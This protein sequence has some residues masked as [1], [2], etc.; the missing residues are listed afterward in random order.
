MLCSAEEGDDPDLA[1]HPV[2]ANVGKSVGTTPPLPHPPRIAE[3]ASASRDV[4]PH[5]MASILAHA[6]GAVQVLNVMPSS[7]ARTSAES[8]RAQQATALST[9]ILGWKD[10]TGI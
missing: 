8:K 7:E 4:W 3:S 5:W 2:A 9:S 10:F 1:P 6:D